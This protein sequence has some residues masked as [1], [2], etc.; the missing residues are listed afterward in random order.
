MKDETLVWINYSKENLDSSKIL[1]ESD[2]YNPCLQNVQQ[3]VE[4]SLKAV[5]IERSFP[6]KKT[7]SILELK[8]IINDM[9]LNSILPDDDCDFLDSVYLPSKYP[10]M[11]VLPDYL[12]DTEIC[13]K[14]IIIA[15]SVYI[16]VN[17]L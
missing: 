5:I 10:L 4:K 8:N 9:V 17:K 16:Y 7:H 1:L 2:L 6:F 15:E 13:R 14:A 12:P 11:S 3:S